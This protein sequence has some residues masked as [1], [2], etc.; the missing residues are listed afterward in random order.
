MLLEQYLMQD[1]ILFLR[2]IA[3]L[4]QANIIKVHVKIK[5]SL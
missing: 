4:C 3:K 2:I 5:L 1:N